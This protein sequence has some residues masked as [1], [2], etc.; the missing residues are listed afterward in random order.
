MSSISR[1]LVIGFG[2]AFI[3]LSLL[4]GLFLYFLLTGQLRTQRQALLQ[5][6]L[7][8]ITSLLKTS[9][10]GLTELKERVE[11][12]WPLRGGERVFVEIQDG[13]GAL[14]TQSPDLSNSLVK[15]LHDMV[16]GERIIRDHKSQLRYLATMV[17]AENSLGLKGPIRIRIAIGEEQT[18]DF[19]ASLREILFAVFLFNVFVSLLVGW[20]LVRREMQPLARIAAQIERID[21]QN[22]HQR[23][24]I[25]PLPAEL[26]SLAQ[27]FNHSLDRLEEA[28]D[29]LSRFSSDLAHELKSP[30]A[31]MM[32]SIEVALSRPRSADEYRD[33]LESNLEEC[34]RISRIADGLL[35]LARAENSQRALNVSTFDLKSEI[36]SI[37]EFFEPSAAEKSIDLSFSLHSDSEL[38]ISAEKTLFQQMLGNLVNN[39]ISYTSEGGKV[40]VGFRKDQRATILFV[41]DNG[42]GISQKDIPFIFDRF[43]RVDPSRNVRSGGNGLGL[44]IVKSIAHLHNGEVIVESE[45]GKG[46]CFSIRL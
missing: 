28:F 36:K 22:L 3:A 40:E 30:I 15:T 13:G 35:F 46:S 29:R 20:Q 18:S 45:P 2:G 42:V 44:A 34:A 17:Q 11:N 14:V 43:Y 19:L 39:A 1:R 31:N 27:S 4:S 25:D 23:I 32:G 7:D 6:R 12:E 8:A 24:L 16:G 10:H 33:N 5:D 21:S 9:S 26:R 41:R 38:K 37:L